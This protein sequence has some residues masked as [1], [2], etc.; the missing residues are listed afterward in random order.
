MSPNA[1]VYGP[2]LCFNS[3]WIMTHN[4]YTI[5]II[6]Q[7]LATQKTWLIMRNRAVTLASFY[8][9]DLFSNNNNLNCVLS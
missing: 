5:I 8:L 3:F 6:Y 9:N 7:A 4:L 2:Y 1:L